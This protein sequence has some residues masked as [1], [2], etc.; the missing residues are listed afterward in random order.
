MDCGGAGLATSPA[1]LRTWSCAPGFAVRAPAG[2][3]TSAHPGSTLT[4]VWELPVVAVSL[5]TG[6][7]VQVVATAAVLDHVLLEAGANTGLP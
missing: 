2:Q 6:Q 4:P 7:R 3:G 1:L 5:P